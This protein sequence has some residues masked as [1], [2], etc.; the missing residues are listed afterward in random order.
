MKENLFWYFFNLL[1]SFD[2]VS[3]SNV[4]ANKNIYCDINNLFDKRY[5]PHTVLNVW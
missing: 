4:K 5:Q 2:F 1:Q 3:K